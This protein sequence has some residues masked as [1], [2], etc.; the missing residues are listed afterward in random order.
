MKKPRF[1]IGEF[2]RG[3][4]NTPVTVEGVV[5]GYLPPSNI[6]VLIITLLKDVRDT[7]I[8]PYPTDYD[9]QY[10]INLKAGQEFHI[11]SNWCHSIP[12]PIGRVD[13]PF[14]RNLT[15]DL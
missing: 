13:D 11:H 15:P 7:S 12:K 2:V 1:K 8:Q 4:W 9:V 5:T 10:H 6:D 14:D 3:N